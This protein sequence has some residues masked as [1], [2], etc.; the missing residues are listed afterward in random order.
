V[1]HLLEN[2]AVSSIA[3]D[4]S[5]KKWFGTQGAGAYLM[6]ADGTTQL[7]HFTKDNSPMLSNNIYSM[8]IDSESGEVYFGTDEGIISYKGLATYGGEVCSDTYAYPNPVKPGY[9][10][11]I[12]IKGLMRD[13]TVRITDISGKLI[14]STKAEGGQA[15]WDGRSL[16]GDRARSGVYLIFSS[17]QDGSNSCVNKL[18]FI[19]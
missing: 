13:A 19:N 12:A 15:I 9:S 6:S 4:G 11:L 1:E 8:A 3:V 7:Q 14:Y 2:S 5:N 18:I 16:T 17:S 10:G